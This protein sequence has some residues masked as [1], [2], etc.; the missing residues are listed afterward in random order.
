MDW[1][2]F[3]RTGGAPDR[4][5]TGDM[6]R[7]AGRLVTQHGSRVM[8]RGRQRRLPWREIR[9][10]PTTTHSGSLSRNLPVSKRM[11]YETVINQHEASTPSSAETA[12]LIVVRFCPRN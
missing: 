3:R 12:V 9:E 7:D 6:F 5:A 2:R 8:D 10:Q 1:Y 4:N 11:G